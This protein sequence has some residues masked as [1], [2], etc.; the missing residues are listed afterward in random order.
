MTI[1]EQLRE[2]AKRHSGPERL[3]WDQSRSNDR[4]F[5]NNLADVLDKV[6]VTALTDAVLSRE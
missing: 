3:Q 1:S 5:L 6:D 2:I 4:G